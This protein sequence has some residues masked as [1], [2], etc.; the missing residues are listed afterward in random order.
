M[1]LE[2]VSHKESE[3]VCIGKCIGGLL[4]GGEIILLDSD[5]GGG[6]TALTRGLAEGIGSGDDVTSPTFAI[7]QTYT[8]KKL[9]IHHYDLY[10]L[11]TLGEV[12]YEMLEFIN[13]PN[14]VV[15]V[16][17]PGL[18]ESMLANRDK[19]IIKIDRQKSS[20]NERLITIEYSDS[21]DY[22]IDADML[23]DHPC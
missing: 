9:E 23:E 3:T 15:V 21:L 10:R 12:E 6:K 11:D 5:L 22:A 13:E 16:E 14:S 18:A 4:K 19:I 7:N 20:E 2:I 8:G 17:W 1:R